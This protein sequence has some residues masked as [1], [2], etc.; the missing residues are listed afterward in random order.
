MKNGVMKE[1]DRPHNW[2]KSVMDGEHQG[3]RYLFLYMSPSISP[4][5]YDNLDDKSLFDSLMIEY[6][7]QY[8]E[9]R[10]VYKDQIMA[11]LAERKEQIK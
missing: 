2:Q 11:L 4:D 5:Q 1:D 6:D 10:D 8:L 9:L 7:N 3:Y